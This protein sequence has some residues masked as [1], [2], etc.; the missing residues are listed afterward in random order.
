MFDS[1]GPCATVLRFVCELVQ[2]V[3]HT[4]EDG[5]VGKQRNKEHHFMK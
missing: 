5:N 2:I 1:F 3:W 4:F